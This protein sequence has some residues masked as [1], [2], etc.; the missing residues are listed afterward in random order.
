MLVR[1]LWKKFVLFCICLSRV[2][3]LNR[4]LVFVRLVELVLMLLMYMVC[5][6]V[7]VLCVIIMW[8]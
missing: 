5:V 7:V 8:C 2:N 3:W 1:L 4:F 6:F